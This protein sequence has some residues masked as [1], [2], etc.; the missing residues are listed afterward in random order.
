MRRKKHEWDE[1]ATALRGK[2]HRL[3]SVHKAAMDAGTLRARQL[4]YWDHVKGDDHDPSVSWRSADEPLREGARQGPRHGAPS[5]RNGSPSRSSAHR[6]SP[7]I[8]RRSPEIAHR[9]SPERRGYGGRVSSSGLGAE[10]PQ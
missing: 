1:E 7:E 8:R 6:G 5:S 9:G 4:L 2:I 10:S 3:Q